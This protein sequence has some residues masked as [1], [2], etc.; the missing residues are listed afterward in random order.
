[1]RDDESHTMRSRACLHPIVRQIE[2]TG[3]NS[4]DPEVELARMG[5]CMRQIE[6]DMEGQQITKLVHQKWIMML[7]LTEMTEAICSAPGAQ[8]T[9]GF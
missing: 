2:R 7:V 1:M 4:I 3:V 8:T 5:D 9:T 6:A